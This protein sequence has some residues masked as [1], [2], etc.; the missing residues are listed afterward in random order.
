MKKNVSILL[1]VLFALVIS[2]FLIDFH[3]ADAYTLEEL[4]KE[5]AKCAA[6]EGDLERL[7]AYDNLAQSLGVAYPRVTHPDIKGTGKWTFSKKINPVDDTITITFILK[8]DSGTSVYGEPILLV[9]RY[10]SKKIE[11][12][13]SWN[14]YLGNKVS[15]L[16]RIGDEKAISHPWGLST[17]SQATFYP[18][19]GINSDEIK[20]AQAINDNEGYDAFV[21]HMKTQEWSSA[22]DPLR[23]FFV[24]RFIRQLMAVDKFVAQ[25]TPYSESPITAV[26]DLRGLKK[27]V[28]QFN[29]IL[30]WIK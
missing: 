2:T 18:L 19:N 28:E 4:V 26:F 10:K 13:I 5:I 14:S 11:A 29:D 21:E 23:N 27:A 1:I 12:Y 15:V 9:L 20:K 25:V 16:T 3:Y 6:I 8:S 17:D 30:H 24:I 22:N 7:E